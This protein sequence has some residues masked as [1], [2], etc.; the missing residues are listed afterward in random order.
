MTIQITAKPI[1]PGVEDGCRDTSQSPREHRVLMAQHATMA[2]RNLRALCSVVA[3]GGCCSVS[4]AQLEGEHAIAP[5]VHGRTDLYASYTSAFFDRGV[6]ILGHQPSFLLGGSHSA[7]GWSFGADAALSQDGSEYWVEPY[8]AYSYPLGIVDLSGGACLR[9]SSNEAA[10]DKIEL[11]GEA[12][13]DPV[14]GIVPSISISLNLNERIGN[15]IET[16][17]EYPL[18][19][20]PNLTLSPYVTVG[21]GS[22]Y[23]ADWSANHLECGVS[24]AYRLTDNWDLLFTAGAVLPLEGVREFTGNDDVEGTI[25]IGVR[26]RF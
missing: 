10:D 25:G 6:P 8:V 13:F 15:Y 17:L 22:Y 9:F 2:Y 3:L 21:M 11:F 16:K 20:G 1:R 7:L 4:H 14:C 26:F 12:V 23:T 18:Q 19:P 5:E 24:S